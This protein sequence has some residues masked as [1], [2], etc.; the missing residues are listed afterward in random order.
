MRSR[1]VV[2][3]AEIDRRDSSR[4]SPAQP[5]PLRHAVLVLVA[6]RGCRLGCCLGFFALTTTTNKNA[7]FPKP[8]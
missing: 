4:A 7:D 8:P 2:L 1:D 6:R 5:P 3:V